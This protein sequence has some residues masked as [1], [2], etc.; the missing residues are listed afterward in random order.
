[1]TSAAESLTGIT[2]KG[3]WEVLGRTD[4]FDDRSGGVFSVGYIVRNTSGQMAFCKALDY[5]AAFADDVEDT[6]EEL[7]RLT[8]AF[9]FERDVADRCRERKL[10]RVVR[11]L[12]HG[13][14]RVP[15]H[16]Y[17]WVSYLLFE[18]AHGDARDALDGA[19][20]VGDQYDTAL[21]RSHDCAIALTQLH[22]I[23]VS[24]QDVKPA[25]LMGWKDD[26]GW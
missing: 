17:G 4:T 11:A 20:E 10:D 15:G 8:D 22:G 5:S 3:G 18:K 26:G 24:H 21:R 14:V 2:L 16:A 1:M 19:L 23:G 9:L 12:D 6:E 25:N 13:R 7:R